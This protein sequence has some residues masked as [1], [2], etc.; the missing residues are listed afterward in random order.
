MLKD[1]G[2]AVEATVGIGATIPL[3]ELARSVYALNKLAGR[4]ALDFSS[5]VKLVAP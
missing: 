2:L 5:I 1:P 3:G 4:G